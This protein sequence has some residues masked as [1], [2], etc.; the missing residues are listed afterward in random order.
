MALQSLLLTTDQQV[1]HQLRSVLRDLGIG[2]EICDRAA[3]ASECLRR[4]HFDLAVLDCEVPG[5]EEVIGEL[6]TAASSRGAPLFLIG[7]ADSSAETRFTGQADCLLSR[8]LALEHTWRELRTARQQMEFTMFR[9]FRV[10]IDASAL[11]LC[12]GGTTVEARTRDVGQGGVA[13][14]VPIPLRRGETLGVQLHLPGCREVIEAQAEVVWAD[15]KATAGLRF[16]MLADECRSAL[17]AWIAKGL[18]E[19]EFAYVF[20][21]TREMPGPVLIPAAEPAT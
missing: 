20:N 10:R 17:E 5:I 21:G 16:I 2:V 11:L 15:E 3:Q 19:R 12:S 14:Q 8:P 6:R 9:Y 4:E 7:P 13:L 1:R 18:G